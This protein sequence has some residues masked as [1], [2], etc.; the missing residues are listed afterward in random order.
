MKIDGS[1]SSFTDITLGMDG[2]ATGWANIILRCV[3]LGMSFR[4][5]RAAAPRIAEFSELGDFLDLPV[6]TY[7]TGMF[8]MLA[9][10]ISTSVEPEIIIMDEMIGTGDA[11]FMARARERIAYLVQ[12][13]RIMVLAS[14]EAS[15]LR[16]FCNQLVWLERGEVRRI[17]PIDD[18]YAEYERRI[19]EEPAKDDIERQGAA[20]TEMAASN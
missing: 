17:G 16:A 13:S 18:V 14:H 9:F 1:I 6:R 5:A 2:E 3:F 15:I 20:T 8:L 19:T 10:A 4:Q 11:R 12:K 7:S